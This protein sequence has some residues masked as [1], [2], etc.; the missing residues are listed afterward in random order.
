MYCTYTCTR[1]CVCMIFYIPSV[2]LLQNFWF[3]LLRRR[4]HTERRSRWLHIYFQSYIPTR[5]VFCAFN[6]QYGIFSCVTLG[7]YSQNFLV[8]RKGVSICYFLDLWL[9]FDRQPQMDCCL[10]D[11]ATRCDLYRRL[12]PFDPRPFR[13]FPPRRCEFTIVHSRT[14]IT[15]REL[16]LI[17]CLYVSAWF[18]GDPHYRTIDGAEYT[19]N[20]LG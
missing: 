19:F 12:R 3:L 1:T 7:K 15:H 13:Y 6:H 10:A 20:G 5:Y 16:S 8:T 2:V 4:A 11:G 14:V 17:P 18:F 9:E